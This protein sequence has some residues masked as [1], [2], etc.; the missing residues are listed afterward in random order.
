MSQPV[1]NNQIIMPASILASRPYIYPPV[2]TNGT[3]ILSAGQINANVVLSKRNS[4][5]EIAEL[6]INGIESNNK[7]VYNVWWL[8][9]KNGNNQFVFNATPNYSSVNDAS[10]IPEII[11]TGINNQTGNSVGVSFTY[12]FAPKLVI[13]RATDYN[14][15][16]GS[17]FF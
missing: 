12:N 4:P 15:P 1:N 9:Y 3:A 17:S 2:N 13:L 16:T 10:V 5:S 6:L 14:I 11:L 8:A 7:T